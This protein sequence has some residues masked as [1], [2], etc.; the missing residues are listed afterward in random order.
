MDIN[1]EEQL[2]TV[3]LQIVKTQMLGAPGMIM[4][5]FG[6]YGMFGANGNAFH[7]LLNDVNIVYGLLAVG[8][9][10]QIWQFFKV[11]P[12]IIKQSQIQKALNTES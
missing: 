8:A 12:L 10:I 11:I 1:N 2:R 6:L 3:K 9:A 4:L 5:G 7:P